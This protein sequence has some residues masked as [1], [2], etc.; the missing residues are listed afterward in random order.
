MAYN[1]SLTAAMRS[2]LLQLQGTAKLLDQT[3]LRISTGKK[4][5]SAI[6]GPNEFFTAR[7]LSDKA[8]DFAALKDGMGQAISAIQTADKAITSITDLVSQAKALASSA[9]AATT[10][11]ERSSLATQ[12]DDLLT[13]VDNLA[14][15]AVYDGSNLVAGRGTVSGGTWSVAGKVDVDALSG[16][17]ASTVTT[18]AVSSELTMDLA[19]Q[20]KVSGTT[21]VATNSGTFT[22][23]AKDGQGNGLTLNVSIGTSAGGDGWTSR[24]TDISAA[25]STDG[26]TLTLSDGTNSAQILTADIDDTGNAA[27]S[28]TLGDLAVQLKFSDTAGDLVWEAGGTDANVVDISGTNPEDSRV[29]GTYGNLSVTFDDTNLSRTVNGHT[30]TLGAEALASTVAGE[31]ATLTITNS[32]GTG[33]NDKAVVFNQDGSATINVQA[34]D[35]TVSGLSVATAVGSWATD[36]NI[37]AALTDVDAA[38]TSLRGY[39]RNLAT[40]LGVIQTREEFTSEFIS[41]LQSGADKLTLADG[42]EEA[43][44]MLILQTRQ[45]LG[46]QALNMASQSAQSILSLFR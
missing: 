41:N 4:I 23:D 26:L 30:V 45:Q 6:D 24:Y 27:S 22:T 20:S 46:L 29:I 44:N 21:S 2:N 43:A 3:Q 12:F 39:S 7:G 37:D 32:T 16:Y 10:A 33:E 5:N 15:D 8:N 25:V 40:N 42:N 31:T 36:A 35:A 13:Q 1:I 11:S 17:A 18:A 34:V 28:V 9:R 14:G 38:I 19:V